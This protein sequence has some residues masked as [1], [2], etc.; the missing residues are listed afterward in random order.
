MARQPTSTDGSARA[1]EHSA[2]EEVALGQEFTHAQ[3]DALE[4]A[5][6]V[7]SGPVAASEHALRASLDPALAGRLESYRELLELYTRACP[8]EEPPPGLL[9]GGGSSTAPARGTKL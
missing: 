5:L 1:G 6:E 9:D 4:D 2:R 8:I 7:I 3:L